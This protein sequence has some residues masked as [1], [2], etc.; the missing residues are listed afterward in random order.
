MHGCG[1]VLSQ[2]QMDV[3]E[4]VQKLTARSISGSDKRLVAEPS[5]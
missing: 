5:L 1:H 4:V 3:V 2:N